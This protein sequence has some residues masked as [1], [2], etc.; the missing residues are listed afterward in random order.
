MSVTV[1]APSQSSVM[2]LVYTKVV[3]GRGIGAMLASISGSGLVSRGP[4]GVVH[5]GPG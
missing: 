3:R 2:T 4:Q 5:F 1:G